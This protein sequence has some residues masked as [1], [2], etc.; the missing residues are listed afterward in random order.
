MTIIIVIDTRSTHA[1]S[2]CSVSP[3]SFFILVVFSLELGVP[4]ESRLGRVDAAAA[5]EGT[6]IFRKVEWE[7]LLASEEIQ[8]INVRQRRF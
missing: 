1:C 4:L 7:R 5:Q 6:L 2:S 8:K 3:S